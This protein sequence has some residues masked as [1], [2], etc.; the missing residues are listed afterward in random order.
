MLQAGMGRR[1]RRGQVCLDETGT[2][3]VGTIKHEKGTQWIVVAE[4][5]RASLGA[6]FRSG[7]AKDC[8]ATSVAGRWNAT[9]A[10]REDFR[11]LVV[12]LDRALTGYPGFFHLA[13]LPITLRQLRNRLSDCRAEV[14]G[15]RR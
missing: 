14:L 9:S 13:G 6:Y 11:W 15:E 4:Y 7:L 8:V 5:R 1:L 12:C 3:D 2:R 10:C